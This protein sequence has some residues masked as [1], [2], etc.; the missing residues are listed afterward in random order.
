VAAP[1]PIPDTPTHCRCGALLPPLRRYGGLCSA[2]LPSAPP[3]R[4]PDPMATAWTIVSAFVRQRAA[5]PE[6]WFV[7][8]CRCGTVREMSSS[9]WRSRH[10]TQ[11]DAC[12][13]SATRGPT[14]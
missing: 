9:K 1:K 13:R 2:C 12:R 5:G 11:C 4:L 8:R 6:N 10:S 7:V 3:S 14:Y